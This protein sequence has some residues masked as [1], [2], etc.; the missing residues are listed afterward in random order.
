MLGEN[1]RDFHA[2]Q[3]MIYS[4]LW[5]SEMFCVTFQLSKT[6]ERVGRGAGHPPI[7]MVEEQERN[8]K[9][10]TSSLK[11]MITTTNG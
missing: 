2:L 11:E 8:K 6:E 10:H 1:G 9:N 3:T 7:L 5:G 4:G